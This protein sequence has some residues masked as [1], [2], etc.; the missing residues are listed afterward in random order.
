MKKLLLATVAA[1]S[2]STALAD[3]FSLT[4]DAPL[5]PR[6]GIAGSINYTHLVTNNLLLGAS[7]KP[8]FQAG[9][10]GLSARAGVKWLQSLYQDRSTN[11]DFY[12]G[13]A[14][15]ASLLPAFGWAAEANG[16]VY[17]NTALSPQV[18]LETGL[19][20][21][22]RYAGNQL[23][24][25]IGGFVGFKFDVISDVDLYARLEA[26]YA[27]TNQ[28]LDYAARVGFYFTPNPQFRIGGSGGYG[29]SGWEVRMSAQFVQEPGTPGT[30]GSYLP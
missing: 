10:F 6:F 26:D 5:H 21:L 20:G 16:G 12:L 4:L 8:A 3:G 2:L 27:F 1:L 30:P 15:E 14:G 29:S 18:K 11:A 23:A 28:K 22:A 17:L 13:L 25:Q 24:P 9:Q 7:L 19:N